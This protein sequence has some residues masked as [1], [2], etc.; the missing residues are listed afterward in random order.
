[1]R[2]RALALAALCALALPG[3]TTRFVRQPVLDEPELRIYLRS[4]QGLRGTIPK[5]YEHPATIAPVR[6]GHILS[7]ID[8]RERAEVGNRREG[9]LPTQS[10]FVVGEGLSQALAKASPD[11]EVVVM[12]LRKER[13]LGVFN[14]S[15]LTSFFSYV[16]DGSLFFHLSRRDWKVEN[17]RDLDLPE[18]RI[19]DDF[20]KVRMQA[21]A[22]MTVVDAQSLAID[23]RDPIFARPT[24]TK[25]LPTGEVVR[26]TI[27]LESPPEEVDD[28]P[29]TFEVPE[30]LTP[31]QLRALAD[32]EE[33]RRA[34][35]VTEPQY[36]ARKRDILERPTP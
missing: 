16:R 36:R 34:G 10:L 9:A 4:E 19:G 13:R 2:L 14:H 20:A 15:Y 3:C 8:V 25:L 23:W 29:E 11:Q 28:L 1:M 7:R 12:L 35:T 18:P 6:L 22:A 17:R 24:R 32:L 30:G 27:L 26:K 31:A 5:G 33:E 21:D